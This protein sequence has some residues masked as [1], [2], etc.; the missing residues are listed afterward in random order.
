MDHQK[1]PTKLEYH[2]NMWKL[3]TQST[4]LSIIQ[5]VEG[6]QAL[7]LESTIFHPQGGGQPSDTGFIIVSNSSIHFVVQDVR[8][9]DGIMLCLGV[10][11][12][13]EPDRKDPRTGQPHPP[14]P[15][16]EPV[17]WGAKPDRKPLG[18]GFSGFRPAGSIFKEPEWMIKEGTCV[19]LLVDECRR[20]LNSRL[21]S[22]GH[23][24]DISIRNV[25]LGHLEPGK[26]NHFPEGP[27]VEYKGIFPQTELKTKQE[28]LEK[29]VNALVSRGGKVTVALLP[30][31]EAA[32]L[33]GG[34]LPHYI[35]KDSRPRIVQLGENLGCPCGGTHVQDIAE[36]KTIKISQIRMKK[37]TTKVFYNISV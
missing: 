3:H 24:L 2:D 22:A 1:T 36:V 31:D 12:G 37:G 18:P 5:S 14:K 21:H 11:T 13:L 34:Q 19:E 33:C 15:G 9:I 23:L 8:S 27:W 6:R 10:F 29:D 20:S 25:G 17:G 28:E 26:A 7:I 35:L 16:T 4:F 32:K 30:Y